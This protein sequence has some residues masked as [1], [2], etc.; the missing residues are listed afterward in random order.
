M[1]NKNA[2]V[3]A[4]THDDWLV[5]KTFRLTGLQESP[6]SFAASYEVESTYTDEQW[7]DSLEISTIMGIFVDGVLAGTMGL[8]A[9]QYAQMQHK[10]R[11]FGVYV[12]PEY[13]G[14]G[15]ADVLMRAVIEH[16]KKSFL[17]IV[18]G[19]KSVNERAIGFYKK[20][21]FVVYGTEPWASKVG[22]IFY[23]DTL[24]VFFFDNV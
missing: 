7:K 16:T 6:L 1:K 20:H 15:V 18:L 11:L 13:R 14:T 23:E 24:M 10:C 8:S 9:Y 22:D 19:V 2:V 3:R 5:W 4:L 12:S 17:Q 21:G